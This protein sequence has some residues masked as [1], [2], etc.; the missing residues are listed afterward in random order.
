MK[1]WAESLV[2]RDWEIYWNSDE[3]NADEP[4]KRKDKNGKDDDS[5]GS[6][7]D[8]WYAG[9]VL[10]ATV[11]EDG[12]VVVKVLFVGDE[13]IYEMEL[14]PSKV[15]P[16]ARGWIKRTTALLSRRHGEL[17]PDTATPEDY[18]H[19]QSQQTVARHYEAIP[20]VTPSLEELHQVLELQRHVQ[21]QMYL[22]S[23]LATI[24]NLHGSIKYIDG[25]PNPTEPLV[26]HLR[27]CCGDLEHAC[28]WYLRC[29]ELLTTCFGQRSGQSSN[30]SDCQ[31]MDYETLLQEYLEY[32]KNCI[33][34]CA[35]LDVESTTS[36]RRQLVSP[37]RRPKRRRKNNPGAPEGELDLEGDFRC[38]TLVNHFVQKL[39][40]YDCWYLPVFAK[41]FQILSHS[42]V[43]P[44][45]HW[46]HKANQILSRKDDLEGLVEDDD[47]SK[48]DDTMSIDSEVEH[49]KVFSYEDVEGCLDAL[50]G[51]PVLSLVDLSEQENALQKKLQV[52]EETAMKVR[53]LLE[54]LADDTTAAPCE[55]THKN[56]TDVVLACLEAI[57]QDLGSPEN[58]CFNINPIGKAGASITREF[59]EGAIGWRRWLLDVQH[60]ACTRERKCFVEDLVKR[61]E[62]LPDLSGTDLDMGNLSERRAQGEQQ[63][64]EFLAG[65]SD[66]VEVEEKYTIE[67]EKADQQLSNLFTKTN[68]QEALRELETLPVLLLVEEKISLRQALMEWSEKAVE[69]LPKDMSPIAFPQLENLY[70]SLQ[71]ISK[72]ESKYRAKLIN[73]L[74]ASEKIDSQIR[75]FVAQE[76]QLHDSNLL[77]RVKRL[78]NLSS[79]WKERAESIIFALRMHGNASVKQ[80][81][82]SLKLPAMVDMKR[83]SD[84]LSEY[85]LLGVDMSG[86][87]TTLIK[88]LDEA[89]QWAS[90]LEINLTKDNL[91]MKERLEVLQQEC[92]SRPKG[93]IMDPT[94]QVTETLVDLLE[95][96]L[97]SKE[98]LDRL[99]SAQLH[100]DEENGEQAFSDMLV[101]HVYPLLAEGIDIVELFSQG[102][103]KMHVAK[104]EISLRYLH[105]SFRIRR[106]ARPFS[107]ER[108]ESHP[109]G[110]SLLNQM[111]KKDVDIK[112]GS[113]LTMYTWVD[114]HLSVMAF[115]RSV[116]ERDG[117]KELATVPQAEILLASEPGLESS[118][119]KYC[120]SFLGAHTSKDVRRLKLLIEEARHAES[121]IRELLSKSRDLRKGSL[122]K[123]DSIRQHLTEV[124]E[125]QTLFKERS[126]GNH[127]LLLDPSLETML[128]HHGKVFTWIVS[129]YFIFGEPNEHDSQ[130]DPC[131]L[132]GP[133]I[134][135][136]F[137]VFRRS[138]LFCS[139]RERSKPAN[140]YP[141]GCSGFFF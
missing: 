133:D 33:L 85:D 56:E 75:N 116:D 86:Y 92:Q 66:A 51:D 6:F 118:D 138:L 106:S 77:E 55:G 123:I 45:V 58:F 4:T 131:L 54:R 60:A 9:R 83:I 11:Q 12:T 119:D 70:H 73:K 71:L 88:V 47:M 26:N 117:V 29:W 59:L 53:A 120:V 80:S 124:K 49:E 42:I 5:Q 69:S 90:R 3:E 57:S 19:I 31:P 101:A 112:E 36:K 136:S 113:P 132:S 35:T 52:I 98:T 50:A 122:E 38:T 44:L 62:A 27:E 72:G 93:L 107:R 25:E 43:N 105:E 110:S 24:V 141:V 140:A 97:R 39:T 96:Y 135:L 15:R 115:V 76:A 40:Q 21:A 82:P 104:V 121:E 125:H 13:Q 78:H 126:S 137:L 1:E 89:A 28:N 81:G 74:R 139:R 63:V 68:V 84:L 18:R 65:L 95:W 129:S 61:M 130:L 67:L 14:S 41:M 102:N 20:S 37:Q 7:I 48:E 2:C 46:K 94:R 30:E 87:T 16:S 111:M 108:I 100:S 109:L 99:N 8:D 103:K 114:W 64:R 32:G 127:G 128:D 134:F 79:Q 10:E 23:K 91:P 34:N 17:P 22:R